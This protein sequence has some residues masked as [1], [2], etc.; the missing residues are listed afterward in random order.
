MKKLNKL[1]IDSDKLMK[2]AELV[3]LKG[4]YDYGFCACKDSANNTLCSTYLEYC[5][6]CLV[7]CTVACPASVAHVCAGGK[8]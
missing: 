3:T 4:G 2:N 7:W 8:E 1:Q 6:D 5:T